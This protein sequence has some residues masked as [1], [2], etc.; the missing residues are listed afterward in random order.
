MQLT[1]DSTLLTSSM[2]GKSFC[3]LFVTYNFH[4]VSLCGT[5]HRYLF[6]EK[7]LNFDKAMARSIIICLF[8]QCNA[9]FIDQINN[10][11]F[12]IYDTAGIFE[13]II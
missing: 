9:T 10:Q 5:M 4:N 13:R 7:L 11:F 12:S 2:P 8:K 1:D 6:A 3:A